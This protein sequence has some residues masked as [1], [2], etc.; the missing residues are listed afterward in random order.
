M[1]T[2]EDGSF[3]ED[4]AVKFVLAQ[5]L[6]VLERNFHNG[7]HG[8]IDI[9]GREKDILLFIEVKSFKSGSLLRPAAAVT[10]QKQEKIKNAA[11]TYLFKHKLRA[12][13]CRFD[14]IEISI[15]NG[16]MSSIN[17]IKDAFR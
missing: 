7:H 10:A 16:R 6:Q 12:V 1:T 17:W 14:I 9:I 2:V 5:G 11:N 4:I 8:E 13:P 3:G 15:R